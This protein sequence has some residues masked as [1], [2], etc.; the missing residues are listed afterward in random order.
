MKILKNCLND[1][2]TIVFFDFEGTQHSQ[3]IIAIGAIKVDIDAKLQVIKKYNHFKVYVKAKD[4]VGPIVETL[5]GNRGIR[6]RDIHTS[7]LSI[8]VRAIFSVV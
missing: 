2:K 8:L 5:T 3:E 6:V 4:S 7:S 1:C